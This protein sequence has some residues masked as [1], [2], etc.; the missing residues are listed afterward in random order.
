MSNRSP[1]CSNPQRGSMRPHGVDKSLV[2]RTPFESMGSGTERDSGSLTVPLVHRIRIQA[3]QGPVLYVL[4][5][6]VSLQGPPP[7]AP[8]ALPPPLTTSC[9]LH[10]HPVLLVLSVSA[11]TSWPQPGSPQLRGSSNYPI[12]PACP[13]F[14]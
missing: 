5:G 7:W 14:L 9:F 8:T 13:S 4:L 12:S 3:P 2:A 11:S 6:F 1:I 10:Q